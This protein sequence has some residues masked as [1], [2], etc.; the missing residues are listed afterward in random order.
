MRQPAI[1]ILAGMG[2][3]STAPFVDLV[4]PECQ[5]QYGARDDIDFQ[6]MMISSPSQGYDGCGSAGCLSLSI[7]GIS[8]ETVG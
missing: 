6:K 5:I 8:S 7:V 4:I 2:P 1:G 3:R